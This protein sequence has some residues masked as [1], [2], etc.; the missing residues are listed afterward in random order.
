MGIE[1]TV[2]LPVTDEIAKSGDSGKPYVL[3]HP[4]SAHASAFRSL[5]AGVVAD[6]E[7]MERADSGLPPVDYD[8]EENVITIGDNFRI[9][10]VELRAKCRCAECV[11]EFTGKP[12][13]IQQLFQAIRVP[14]SSAGLVA[15]HSCVDWNN[16]H[17]SLYPYKWILD[18]KE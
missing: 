13:L 2:S 18:G 10:P 11:E 9:D 16:G 12:L 1:N 6:V 7:E 4:D 14:P 8:V 3:S 5:A 15:T 17:K